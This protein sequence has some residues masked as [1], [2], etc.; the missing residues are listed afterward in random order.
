MGGLAG[1]PSFRARHLPTRHLKGSEI[2][3]PIPWRRALYHPAVLLSV[4]YFV[5]R[6][7]LRIDPD[8]DETERDAEILVLRHQLAVLKRTNPRPWLRRRDRM[9]MR[10]SRGWFRGCAGPGS[11]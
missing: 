8:G 9:L 5:L 1:S 7:V 3:V 10:P 6:L 11:S 2:I 4:G